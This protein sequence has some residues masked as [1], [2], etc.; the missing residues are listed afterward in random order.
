MKRITI[1]GNNSGRNAGDMAILGNQ[2]RDIT[3]LYDGLEFL[4]T[5]TNPKYIDETFGHFNVKPVSMQPWHGCVKNF[6]WPLYRAMTDT[7]LILICDNILFDR[8]FYNPLFNN[9]SSIALFAPAAHK[10]GIPI[11]LYNVSV[12]PID[13]PYGK[14]ALQKVL[15]V[16]DLVVTRDKATLEIF[17]ELDLTYP[18]PL[19]HADCALNTEPPSAAEMRKIVEK[20]GLFTNPNGTVGFNVNAY[21]DNWSMAGTYTRKDFCRDVA[22]AA[23]KVIEDLGVDIVFFVTQIMDIPVT[24]QTMEKIRHRDRIKMITNEHY[25]YEVITGLIKRVELHAGLRTHPLIFA[26]AMHTPMIG[27][28][29]YPKSAG[30]LRTMGMEQWQVP[31]DD[32]SADRLAGKIEELWAVRDQVAAELS[33]RAE[34]EKNKAKSTAKLLEKYLA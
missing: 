13:F 33:T 27:L 4:V 16:T 12:G 6:G 14:Q 31:L 2:L 25:N 3:D 30:F 32:L 1:L 26:A 23:D 5:T 18:E 17:D 29:S 8:K 7:D 9:L 19:V 24:R 34:A 22:G 20:E 21:I 11:V 15:D 10:K 28:T